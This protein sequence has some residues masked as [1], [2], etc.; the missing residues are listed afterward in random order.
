MKSFT[1]SAEDFI[2]SYFNGD[3]ITVLEGKD[4]SA[5]VDQ[6]EVGT[7]GDFSKQV[8]EMREES[9]PQFLHAEGSEKESIAEKIFMTVL[10]W[11]EV[12]FLKN[13]PNSAK[14][15]AFYRAKAVYYEDQLR[16]RDKVVMKLNDDITKLRVGSG[17]IR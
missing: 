15:T 5:W 3:I 4:Y 2:E 11:R 1:E 14:E 7:M 6:F 16:E 10:Q 8:K 12:G 17:A 13:N 9:I